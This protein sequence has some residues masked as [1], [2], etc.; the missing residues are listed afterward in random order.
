MII[1]LRNRS[2]V[3][4]A[5]KAEFV[6][7]FLPSADDQYKSECVCGEPTAMM[8]KNSLFVVAVQVG[9]GAEPQI[10]DQTTENIQTSQPATADAVE[11]AGAENSVRARIAALSNRDPQV[12][13]KAATELGEMRLRAQPAAAALT[14]ALHDDDAQVRVDRADE[15]GILEPRGCR[16]A[17]PGRDGPE[18]GRPAGPSGGAWAQP[19]VASSA[20]TMGGF[21][22]NIEAFN[23]C[24]PDNV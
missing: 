17:T 5:G 14:S 23:R 24:W 18:R 13:R 4:H 9:C 10:S 12:R 20:E 22:A 21:Q 2:K 7:A 6:H 3:L 11:S 15:A 19:I 16:R 8:K 1:M